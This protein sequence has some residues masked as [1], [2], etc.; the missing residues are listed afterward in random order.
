MTLDDEN[1]TPQSDTP[2]AARPRTRRRA[3]SRPAGPP[4]VDDAAEA[5]PET[6]AVSADTDTSAPA[7]G[8]APDAGAAPAP[9][10]RTR[11]APTRVAAPAADGGAPPDAAT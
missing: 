7:T 11:R 8:A 5:T 10:K 6:S 2:P 4:A 9:R 3:A 1:L